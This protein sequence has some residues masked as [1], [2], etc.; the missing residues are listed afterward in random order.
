LLFAGKKSKSS[1][2][3]PHPEI[4]PE[5][6]HLLNLRIPVA[7]LIDLLAMKLNSLSPKDIIHIEILDDVSLISPDVE[8]ELPPALRE[9]LDEARKIIA[10]NKPDVEG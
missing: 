10:E 7:P 6:T 4:H 2:P 1:Q 3:Y 5:E 9:R 8:R